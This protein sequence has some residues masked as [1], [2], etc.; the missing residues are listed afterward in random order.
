MTAV[1]VDFDGETRDPTAPDIGAD[2]YTSPNSDGV[3]WIPDEMNTIQGAINICVSGDSIKVAAGTYAENIDFDGKNIVMIG[4]GPGLSIIDG[5]TDGDGTGDGS[6]VTF[7]SGES[8]AAVL[9]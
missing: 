3:V 2:E 1:T 5:D 8:S 4:A 9:S 6:V 7:D